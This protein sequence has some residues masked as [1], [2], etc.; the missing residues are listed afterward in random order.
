V[1]GQESH[2]QCSPKCETTEVPVILEPEEIMVILKEL[3]DPLHTM[4]ELDAFTGLR[5]GELIGPQWGDVDFENLVLHIRRSVVSMVEGLPKTEA[6]QKEVPFGC[7][8]SRAIVPVEAD[9]PVHVTSRLGVCISS[10]EGQTTILAGN[11]MALLWAA[12]I[13]TCAGNKAGN[14]S[15][16][17][18]YVRNA[19]ER[20]RRRLFRNYCGIPA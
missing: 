7:P 13:E 19:P 9:L 15:H 18:T 16:V 6:F 8:I 14:I 3:S 20:Q 4:I 10:H 1:D 11:L 17:S 5:R 2:Q 12:R